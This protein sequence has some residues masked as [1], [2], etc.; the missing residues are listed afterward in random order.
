MIGVVFA[1]MLRRGWKGMLY[2]GIGLGLLGLITILVIPNVDALEQIQKLME[3][4]PPALIKAMGMEDASQMATPEGFLGGAYFGRVILIMAVY[5]VIAGLNV[6]ANDEDQGIMDMVLSLPLPRRQIVLERFAA[7]SLMAFVIL[8]MGFV[9]VYLGSLSI[10][11]NIGFEKLV[12]GNLNLLPSTLVMLAFTMFAGTFFRTKGMATSMA[13]LFVIG[14]YVIDVIGGAASGTVIA[15]LRV[16]S[17]F[18]YLDNAHVMQNG[19]NMGSVLLLSGVVALL[20]VASVW[21][22][23]RRDVGV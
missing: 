13:A 10:A 2:W 17:F 11:L 14:S 23:Q 18:S 9:G 7:Q 4:L 15:Q 1:E 5:A 8:L 6:T 19:L 22:F 12:M 21:S 3:S 16:I 20:V